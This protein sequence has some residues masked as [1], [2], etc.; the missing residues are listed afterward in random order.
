MELHSLFLNNFN[1]L[2][3]ALVL[4][5]P[6]CIAGYLYAKFKSSPFCFWLF[7]HLFK[8]GLVTLALFTSFSISFSAG[9][10]LF[11]FEA[12]SEYKFVNMIALCFC[13]TVLLA[14]VL[15]LFCDKNKGFG[16]Y[17]NKFKD[18]FVCQAY[19]ALTFLY[20]TSLGL[21]ISLEADYEEGTIIVLAFCLLFMLYNLTNLPFQNVYQNYRSNIIHVCFFVILMVGNYYRSMKSTTA[22]PDKVR[23]HTPSM[24]VLGCL[25]IC[26][27]VSSVVLTY[28]IINRIKEACRGNKSNRVRPQEESVQ[29][30]RPDLD[31]EK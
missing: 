9:I 5:I 14:C 23:I 8:E 27:I 26:V 16:E 22:L 6:V 19:I 20:R 15:G 3:F 21:Y 30:M 1:V 11:Y 29:T 18:G 2:L 17:K 4:W 12:S 13:L 7:K 28:E 24:I 31:E 10:Y 25:G